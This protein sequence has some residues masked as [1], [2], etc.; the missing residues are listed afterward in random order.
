MIK[1]VSS[2]KSRI[3]VVDD[4]RDI[5]D[6]IGYHLSKSGK[7]IISAYNGAEALEKIKE[8]RPDLMILDVMMPELDGYE[9]WKTLR[10]Q[11]D[12]ATRDIPVVMLTARVEVE[13]KIKG[14]SIGADD[15]I[16]N[17]FDLKELVLRTENLLSKRKL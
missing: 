11:G 10:H 1:E 15:Y 14:L 16:A 5:V 12:P 4:E 2:I 3:L 17:P 8:S 9:V 7:E 6:L 13:D